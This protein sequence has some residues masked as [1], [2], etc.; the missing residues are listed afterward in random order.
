[1]SKKKQL[2][3]EFGPP[4]DLVTTVEGETILTD[5]Q[6]GIKPPKIYKPLNSFHIKTN[7]GFYILTEDEGVY[8]IVEIYNSS[9]DEDNTTSNSLFK[10]TVFSENIDAFIEGLISIR[11]NTRETT[12]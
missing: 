2:N 9:F 12:S 4:V 6:T 8:N 3:V 10:V 1:M 5:T 7:D 11:E